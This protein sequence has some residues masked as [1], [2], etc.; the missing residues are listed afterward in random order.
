M[1]FDDPKF[2]VNMN[3]EQYLRYR[4][5]IDH[6]KPK[7]SNKKV[8][9]IIWLCFSLILLLFLT[10]YLTDIFTATPINTVY[11]FIDDPYSWNTLAKAFFINNNVVF[12]FLIASIGLGFIIHGVGFTIIKR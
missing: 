3:G 4:E 12:F 11:K 2:K 10:V 8:Q 6:N 7:F 5:Y 1:I 9:G